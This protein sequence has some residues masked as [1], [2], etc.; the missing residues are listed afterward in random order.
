MAAIITGISFLII[1][2]AK[3]YPSNNAILLCLSA[4]ARYSNASANSRAMD[5][6]ENAIHGFKPMQLC[7]SEHFHRTKRS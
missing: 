4:N 3:S 2:E 1:F 5:K 6:A 7:A